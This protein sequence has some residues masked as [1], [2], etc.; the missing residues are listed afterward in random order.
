MKAKTNA[1]CLWCNSMDLGLV[2]L[3]RKNVAHTI[4]WIGYVPDKMLLQSPFM[5]QK[6]AQHIDR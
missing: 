5:F 6:S 3:Q 4:Y 1:A 2:A